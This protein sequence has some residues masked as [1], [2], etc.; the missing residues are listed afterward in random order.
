M[1]KDHETSGPISRCMILETRVVFSVVLAPIV[2][3]GFT[4]E[5][6]ADTTAFHIL[7]D[8]LGTFD[9]SELLYFDVDTGR[10]FVI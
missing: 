2:P 3:R 6:Q 5:K 1:W 7:F 9:H 10:I 4:R 8:M